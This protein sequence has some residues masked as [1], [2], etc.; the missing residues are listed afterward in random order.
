MS[1]FQRVFG[2]IAAL[3]TSASAPVV[4]G[5]LV[6]QGPEVPERIAIGGA[7]SLSIHKLPGGG[8]I[9][10]AMGSDDGTIA[11]RGVFVGPDAAQ[12]A[13]VLDIMR[14]QGAPLT[15]SF[16]DYTYSVVISHYV[17][18]YASRGSV[19]SYRIKSEVLPQALP[20]NSATEDPSILIQNDLLTSAS[21]LQSNAATLAPLSTITTSA[22]ASN[23]NVSLAALYGISSTLPANTNFQTSSMAAITALQYQLETAAAEVQAALS[24][25]ASS[26]LAVAAASFLSYSGTTLALATAQA[27]IVA[28]LVTSGSY[29]NRANA[30]LA[31]V[32]GRSIL[33]IVHA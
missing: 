12:R 15:L 7:Q 3:A 28:T 18:D 5:S 23:I 27:G 16:G 4:I 30:G 24:S 25:L 22:D 33:P 11:W 20:L 14:Q 1:S 29:L 21:M 26:A 2:E 31:Q 32:S 8:R 6:L 19:I 13:R 9:V 10:D 17:Y